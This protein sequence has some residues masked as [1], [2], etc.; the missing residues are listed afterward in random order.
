M[1]AA[2]LELTRGLHAIVDRED[3]DLLTKWRWKA[4]PAVSTG[5]GACGFYACR[6]LKIRGGKE[7]TVYLH[8]FL[9][10]AG[11]GQVVDHANG[12]KLDNRRANLRICTLSENAANRRYARSSGFRGVHR[13]NRRWKAVVTVEGTMHRIGLFDTPEDAARAYDEAASRL[14][15]SYAILNF[16][17]PK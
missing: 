5:G 7:S 4:R 12:D 8:R 15:G 1:T 2:T 13:S 16:G 14:F 6:T 11:P 17:E 10:G 9:M 3:L